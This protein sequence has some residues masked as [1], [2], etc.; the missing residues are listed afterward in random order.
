VDVRRAEASGEAAR[1]AA[2]LD[3][4]LPL[5]AIIAEYAGGSA[6]AAVC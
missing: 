4:P 6:G 2:V 1:L 5:A 3:L